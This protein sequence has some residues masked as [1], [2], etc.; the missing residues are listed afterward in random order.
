L[1]V[2]VLNYYYEVAPLTTAL[3]VVV[4]CCADHCLFKLTIISSVGP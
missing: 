4:F 2:N 3:V 1:H